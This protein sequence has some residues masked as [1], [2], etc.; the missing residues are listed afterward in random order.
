M[1]KFQVTKMLPHV[2]RLFE[3]SWVSGKIASQT[4]RSQVP[5]FQALKTT[6][7]PALFQVQVQESL[8]K[9]SCHF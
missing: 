2:L 6:V 5:S 3:A 1:G 4:L 9:S 7:L 8:W